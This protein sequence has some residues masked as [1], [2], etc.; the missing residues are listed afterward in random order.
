M[1]R[2]NKMFRF[3]SCFI[4]HLIYYSVRVWIILVVLL[5][6]VVKRCQRQYQSKQLHC[7]VETFHIVGGLGDKFDLKVTLC[8]FQEHIFKKNDKNLSLLIFMNEYTE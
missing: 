6:H 8:S 7:T 4:I 1:V 3:D 2:V 5:L